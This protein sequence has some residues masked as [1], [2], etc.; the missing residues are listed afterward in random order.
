MIIFLVVKEDGYNREALF[1]VALLAGGGERMYAPCLTTKNVKNLVKER[2]L[3]G[4]KREKSEKREEGKEWKNGGKEKKKS[5]KRR[6][7]EG[8]FTLD[9]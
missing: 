2:E 4:E 3:S 1:S 5:E 8:Y 7:R 6:N 9:R